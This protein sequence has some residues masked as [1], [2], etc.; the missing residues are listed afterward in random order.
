M[1]TLKI[2]R[3]DDSEIV[4]LERGKVNAIDAEMMREL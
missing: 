3:R 1:G 4:Q 2:T